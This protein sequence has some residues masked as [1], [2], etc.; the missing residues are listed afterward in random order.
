MVIRVRARGAMALTVTPMLSNSRAI[1]IVMP[2][3]PAFAVA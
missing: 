2:T 1:V 3:M